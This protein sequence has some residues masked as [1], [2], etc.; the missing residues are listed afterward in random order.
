MTGRE[1][2]NWRVTSK[3]VRDCRFRKTNIAGTVVAS[4]YCMPYPQPQARKG[5]SFPFLLIPFLCPLFLFIAYSSIARLSQSP[6]SS[7]SITSPCCFPCSSP[8]PLPA[9]HQGSRSEGST[10]LR[11]SFTVC[12]F[13][14][15]VCVCVYVCVC[16]VFCCALVLCLVLGCWL[17]CCTWSL[18]LF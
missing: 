2:F 12:L 14:F 9:L 6:S 7:S 8:L 10:S 16:S 4:S 1:G 15:G 13:T 11:A 3:A 18:S 5:Y 17:G